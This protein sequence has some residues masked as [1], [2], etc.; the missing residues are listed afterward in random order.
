M[1][2]II[3]LQVLGIHPVIH[4]IIA[5]FNTA[6]CNTTHDSCNDDQQQRFLFIIQYIQLEGKSLQQ[7]LSWPA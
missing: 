3:P 7:L 5:Q 2:K 1:I 6:G 4:F